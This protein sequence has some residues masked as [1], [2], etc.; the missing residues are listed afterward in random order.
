M[1][2]NEIKALIKQ[3]CSTLL[4]QHPETE[5][6][7]ID[8]QQL[9]FEDMS[10]VDITLWAVIRKDEYYITFDVNT[11]QYGLGF[12]NIFNILIFLGEYKNPLDAYQDLIS[13]TEM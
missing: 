3:Q 5:E 8:P 1:Q 7:F 6:L 2:S 4:K 11:A 12:K 9:T 10:G 13:R